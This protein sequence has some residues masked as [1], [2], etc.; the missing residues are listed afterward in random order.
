MTARLKKDIRTIIEVSLFLVWIFA[1]PAIYSISSWFLLIFGIIGITAGVY[2]RF[3]MRYHRDIIMLPT[4]NDESSKMGLVAFGLIVLFFSS[5]GHF[6]FDMEIY[7]VAIGLALG[8][9]LIWLGLHESPKGWLAVQGNMIEMQG[10]PEQIDSRLLK[11]ISIYNDRI[12]LTNIYNER[13]QGLMLKLTPKTAQNIKVF[14]DS[15]IGRADISITD[16]VSNA[17][18][19]NW[20]NC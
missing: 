19:R 14:L 8:G 3:F 17:S 10:L 7:Q 16:Y 9:V 15:K 2:R 11:G 18:V 20:N 1:I 12:I 5:V 4:Q 6:A 13:Q